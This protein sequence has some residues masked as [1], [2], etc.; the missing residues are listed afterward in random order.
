MFA[1]P[2][3]VR[4]LE[5]LYGDSLGQCQVGYDGLLEGREEDDGECGKVLEGIGERPGGGVG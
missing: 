4:F 5:L 2:P 1:K 3:T